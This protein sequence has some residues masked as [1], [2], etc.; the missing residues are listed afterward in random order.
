MGKEEWPIVKIG[1]HPKVQVQ[2][3]KEWINNKAGQKIY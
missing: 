3:L 1:R 2:F